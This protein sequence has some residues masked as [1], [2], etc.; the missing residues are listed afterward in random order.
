MFESV[1]D[2]SDLTE[3]DLWYLVE[4]NYENIDFEIDWSASREILEE[5]KVYKLLFRNKNILSL[6]DN[7]LVVDGEVKVDKKVNIV[8]KQRGSKTKESKHH[9]EKAVLKGEFNDNSGQLKVIL[10]GQNLENH[11]D[12]Y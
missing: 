3:D 2:V 1:E 7:K 8:H 4:S 10:V 5:I 12:F 9:I 11:N 6:K